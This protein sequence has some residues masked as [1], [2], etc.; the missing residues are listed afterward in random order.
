MGWVEPFA[1][2]QVP[3]AVVAGI[4]LRHVVDLARV[5]GNQLTLFAVENNNFACHLGAGHCLKF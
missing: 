2:D 1:Q 4:C 3:R 5:E